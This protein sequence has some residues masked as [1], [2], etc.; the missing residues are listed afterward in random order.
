MTGCDSAAPAPTGDAL[1]AD[2]KRTYMDYREF[3]NGV[4]SVL[5]TGPW[6]IGQLGVYGMQPD[7]CGNGAGY[8]FDLNRSLNLDPSTRESNADAVEDHLK[9]AGLSPSR[10]VLGVGDESLIQVAVRDQGGFSQLL[11]EFDGQGRVRVAADTSCRPG[12]AH[13]L[14][15]MLFGDEVFLGDYLPT[16]IE[17]PTDPLFFGI[18]PGDPQF[19]RETPAP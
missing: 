6:E 1:Y 19:V 11:I 5:S 18:T 15:D 17:S 12:D 9:D 8:R 13:E 2:A 4:Q 10:R 3:V 16:D 14:S 7:Q